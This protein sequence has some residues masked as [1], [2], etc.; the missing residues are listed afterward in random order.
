MILIGCLEPTCFLRPGR[1]HINLFSFQAGLNGL[2]DQVILGRSQVFIKEVA[3]FVDLLA[4]FPP[5]FR[6]NV[7]H[8]VQNLRQFPFLADQLDPD[9]IQALFAFCFL[10]FSKPLLPQFLQSIK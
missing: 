4:D 1:G 10:D 3:E 5:L 7:L 8:L 6:S 9:V 2:F